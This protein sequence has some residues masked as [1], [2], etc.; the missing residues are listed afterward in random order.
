MKKTLNIL[1]AL[2]VVLGFIACN[3]NETSN[4]TATNTKQNKSE[5]TTM[6]GLHYWFAPE[7]DSAKVQAT[8]ACDCCASSYLFLND[9][10][11]V[12]ADWCVGED[13]YSKGTYHI[14]DGIISFYYDSLQVSSELNWDAELDT[15]GTVFPPY[16][17]N[18][19][20][21]GRKID[22]WTSFMFKEKI[23]FHNEYGFATP[24]N[25][26]KEDFI[27]AVKQDSIWY[28]LGLK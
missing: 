3:S 10:E 22:K 16:F 27:E 9:S 15:T 1:T 23:C 4:T 13:W 24:N 2:L 8:G 21:E 12:A 28:K 14:Q 25:E 18:I 17:I 11:F 26:G 20:K 5:L 6:S 19:Q 7:L